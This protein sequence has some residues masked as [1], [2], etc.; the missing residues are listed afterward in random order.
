MPPLLSI[1]VPY[2][3]EKGLLCRLL[4]TVPRRS[5]AEVLVVDDH[6][7][8]GQEAT[9]ALATIVAPT[10]LRVEALRCDDK[11]HGSGHARNVGMRLAE[12][13]WLCFAD[14]DDVFTP[15]FEE[16]VN[17]HAADSADVVFFDAESRDLA[18]GAPARRTKHLN[19]YI[20]EY[21]LGQ[22]SSGERH[23]RLRFGEPWCRL[24]CRQ[25]ALGAGLEF[26]T[27]VSLHQDTR[28]AYLLGM[29]AQR[30][31]VDTAV[32]YCV[33]QRSGSLSGGRR[34]EQLLDRV[35]VFAKREREMADQ[36][37]EELD[38]Y[39]RLHYDQTADFLVWGE[40]D[41]Y[42]QARDILR[43]NR[44]GTWRFLTHSRPRN[45][46]KMALSMLGWPQPPKSGIQQ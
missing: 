30:V 20:K 3:D 38:T 39:N 22:H 26:D 40:R 15:A 24:I 12:G 6:S 36:G 19:Q 32:G 18:T 35:R 37:V 27:T 13:R 10:L 16:I 41:L 28:F 9:E 42:A 46:L 17:R 14:A 8:N 45:L 33:T 43:A 5:D 21:S 31:S 34:A 11:G 2:R 1:V 4:Q 25:W 29:S 23:L 7:R 44:I